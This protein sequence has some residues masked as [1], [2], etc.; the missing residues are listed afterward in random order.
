MNSFAAANA[1]LTA[2]PEGSKT[3]KARDKG[4]TILVLEDL[5]APLENYTAR[6]EA[7]LAAFQEQFSSYNKK[8][9]YHLAMGPPA[10]DAL[11]GRVE[12][13]VGFALPNEL[14]TLMSQFNG[15]SF[16]GAELARG[17]QAP[18]FPEEVLPYATLAD[19]SHPLWR[20]A[21]KSLAVSTIAIPTWE[22]VFLCA[23]K[24]RITGESPYG[25]KE[26]LK[27]GKLK[28]K[29]KDFYERLYP[30]DL[31][32]D[33]HGAALYADPVA[34]EFKIIYATDHWAD[35][36][37]AHPVPLRVYMECLIGMVSH[38]GSYYEQRIIKPLS[39]TAWP[40]YIKNIHNSAYIFLE[41]RMH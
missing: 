7:A 32:H 12:D 31:F 21:S 41:T 10:S 14:R 2:D 8:M 36:T 18:E 16:V 3:Q 15:L 11:M 24:D 26:K 27:I 20:A 19:L 37:N 4:K 5:G 23:P 30:F 38:R 28:V 25:D 29:A 13:A 34:K 33:Y 6:L 22:D 1:V 35:L 39:K 9:V 40:T 17:A